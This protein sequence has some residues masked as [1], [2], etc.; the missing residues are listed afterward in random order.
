MIGNPILSSLEVYKQ[1][2]QWKKRLGVWL[3]ENKLATLKMRRAVA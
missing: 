1:E 3:M 2:E